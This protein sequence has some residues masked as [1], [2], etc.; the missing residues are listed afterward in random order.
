MW[1]RLLYLVDRDGNVVIAPIW[2][3]SREVKHGDLATGGMEHIYDN[4][5]EMDKIK[6]NFED[7]R[8]SETP[9]DER[10]IY[11]F[12]REGN[13]GGLARMGGE[14]NRIGNHWEVDEFS[15]YSLSRMPLDSPF[16]TDLETNDK[17]YDEEKKKPGIVRALGVRKLHDLI[18]LFKKVELPVCPVGQTS[19][20]DD[21]VAYLLKMPN[22]IFRPDTQEAKSWVH[23]IEGN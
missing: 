13:Y 8:Y 9:D 6:V 15:G 18:K 5:K 21:C 1:E 16:L 22:A 11:D 10:T 7:P 20:P 4:G 23:R 3:E 2:Q 14:F 17:A 12:L 19:F